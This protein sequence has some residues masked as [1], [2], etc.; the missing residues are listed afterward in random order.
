MQSLDGE[1]YANMSA[2]DEVRL[3]RVLDLEGSFVDEHSLATA[4]DSG[5]KLER[6]STF[7]KL[8]YGR[9][10]KK[11]IT[12]P[13]KSSEKSMLAPASPKSA[14]S[15]PSLGNPSPAASDAESESESETQSV[16]E[17]KDADDNSLLGNQS[18]KGSFYDQND[19]TS[20]FFSMLGERS[21]NSMESDSVDFNDMYAAETSSFD[22]SSMG[23]SSR[24]TTDL[25]SVQARVSGN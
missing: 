22:E 4:S 16:L 2:L 13:E 17:R 12:S 5:S 20:P 7:A 3:G 19:E 8:W 23:G 6:K 1:S 15:K 9:K 25:S 14:S 21:V 18:D 11:T 10:K 24:M